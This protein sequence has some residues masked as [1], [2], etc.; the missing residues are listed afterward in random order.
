MSFE[1]GFELLIVTCTIFSQKGPGFEG[2]TVY[3][4]NKNSR[5]LYSQTES[6]LTA[7]SNQ[8]LLSSLVSLY[9]RTSFH[10]KP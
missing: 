7:K 5:F 1:C 4:R 2:N 3:S 8:T 9:I 10:V 6:N